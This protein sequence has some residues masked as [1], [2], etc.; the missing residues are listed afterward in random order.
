MCRV[1][2]GRSC[3]DAIKVKLNCMAIHS[4]EDEYLGISLYPLASLINH[5]CEPNAYCIFEGYQIRIRSLQRIS[6]EDEIKLTYINNTV[7]I[8]S[9]QPIL[10]SKW[11]FDC[12]CEFNLI[13]SV[14]LK[15][16]ATKL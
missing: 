16:K 11:L 8:H 4:L 15:R 12:R 7:D 10:K 2:S 13:C 1:S 6:A 3:I 5:S 14:I 9:R